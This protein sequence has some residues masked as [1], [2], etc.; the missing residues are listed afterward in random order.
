[1]TTCHQ[2]EPKGKS[3]HVIQQ[4]LPLGYAWE[5]FRL[6]GK[7]AYRLLSALAESFEYAWQA[8]CALVIELDPRTTTQL[9]GE[10]ERSVSLPDACLPQ[11]VTLDERR[12][13]VMWRLEKRRWTTAQDWHDL[14]ALF[15]L[16]ISI[17][18]GWYVQ[19]PA[20]F[21]AEMPLDFNIFPK[22]GRFRVYIDIL[23]VE[24]PGFEYGAPDGANAEVG[25]PI[26]FSDFPDGHDAFRCIIDR[27]RPANVVV[28]WNEFPRVGAEW[29]TRPTFDPEEFSEA[30]C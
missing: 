7:V 28:I 12:A 29:C 21:D 23:N 24:Y 14:A 10:W 30:F 20:L 27:V 18:P 13:W 16:E 17:T 9:I 25:F 1:M 5:S 4:H 15:G 26:P 3:L 22:L 2:Y 11:A 8:L 19:R 6:A